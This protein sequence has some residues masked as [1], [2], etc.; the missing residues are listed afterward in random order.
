MCVNIQ[1]KVIKKKLNNIIINGLANIII[2][3]KSRASTDAN[4]YLSTCGR[5]RTPMK[6]MRSINNIYLM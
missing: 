1:R 4:T 2:S 3:G 5:I 6:L